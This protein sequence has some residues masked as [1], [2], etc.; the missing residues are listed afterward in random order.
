MSR[1]LPAPLLSLLLFGIWLLLD[2]PP[3]AT[4]VVL[5]AG[6]AVAVPWLAAPLRPQRAH[7]RRPGLVL[8]L[9]ARVVVDS[10]V[11][12]ATM[13][14]SL[15]RRRRER[16]PEGSFVRVPLALSD[17]HGLAALAVITT[18]VPGTVWCEL[19]HDRSAVLLH[20]LEAGDER[21][22]IAHFKECYERP[23]ME[24]FR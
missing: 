3:T 20:V 10:L 8:R 9:C 6:V 23:L 7:L 21:A 5:A 22:F 11:S 17:P 13:I 1:W 24:I 2:M 19:A 15:L 14:R 4:S 16:L 12:N 18:M